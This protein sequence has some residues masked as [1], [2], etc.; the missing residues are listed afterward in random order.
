MNI[1][2]ATENDAKALLSIYAPYVE[3]TAVS[4]EYTVPSV[5][6]FKG[7]IKATLQNYPYLIAEENGKILGYAY[8]SAFHPRVAYSH[9]AEVSIYLDESE[10]RKGIGKALYLKLEEMLKTQ[11]VYSLH[12]C[13]A[14]PDQPDDNL[15]DDSFLFHTKMGYTLS[16]KHK[17]CGYKFGKWYSVIWMDKEIR[18][19]CGDVPQFIPFSKL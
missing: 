16:A 13:I 6:E 18:E 8:G 1:R 10:R 5:N 9:C 17:K 19:K 12:A 4:F 11:N 15:T 14:Y 2:I 7:R 3:N